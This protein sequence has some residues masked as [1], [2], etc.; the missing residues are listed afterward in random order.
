MRKAFLSIFLLLAVMFLSLA[1]PLGTDAATINVTASATDTLNGSDGQCSLREAITNINNAVT[2]YADCVPNGAYGTNDTINIPAGTYTTATTTY[3]IAKNVSIVG[4]GAGATIID[5]NALGRVFYIAD[6]PYTVAISG[7]TIQHG[8]ANLGG[9][10]AIWSGT[11]TV[12]N[13]TITSNTAGIEGGAIYNWFA[14]LTVTKSTISSNTANSGWGGGG[15][16]NVGP[17]TVTNS[18]ITGNTAANGTA[19]GGIFQGGSGG[20]L[21]VINSTISGNTAAAG[22][23]IHTNGDTATL[24]NSI[25]ANQTAGA[26]CSGAITSA[27]H[28]LESGTSCGFT[29]TGDLRSTN[30]VL[31]ALANNGGPTQTMA[32]Q[33]SSPAIDAGDNAICAAASVNGI[34][35]RG[36]PRPAGAKCDIGAFEYGALNTTPDAFSFAAQTG[37]P[38]STAIVSNPI[39][40]TGI[41]SAAAIAISGNSG[42]YSIST[43][44]GSTWGSWTSTPATVSLNNQVK[45]RQPSS[46]SNSTLTTTTLTIG[47]VTGDFNAT[48]AASGDPN[49]SGLVS[50]WKAENNAYDSVGG[51]HGTPMNGTTYATGK[52]GQAFSFDGS[53]QYVFVP[54]SPSLNLATGHTVAFWVKFGAYPV[55]G[56]Y[57]FIANKFTNSAEDKGVSIDSSGRVGYGL[58]GTG[59]GLQSSGVLLPAVWNH[60]VATY[61]GSAMRIYINGALDSSTPASGDVADSTGALYLGY[62]PGRASEGVEQPFNGLLDEVKWYNRALS[63]TD[64]SKLAGTYPDAF[65]FTAQTGMPLSTTI[66]SNPITV[67]GIIATAISIT[68]GEYQINSGS[69]TASAGTVNNGDTV[70]VRQTSSASNSTL[71]TA[72]LTIGG[73]SGAFNVTTA[74]SSD[75]NASGLVAWWRAENNGY[76]SVGGNHGTAHGGTTYATGRAGQAFDLSSSVN[77]YVS[78]PDAANLAITDNITVASWFYP[79]VVT[80]GLSIFNRRN[81]SNEGGVDLELAHYDSY[82]NTIGFYVYTSAGWQMIFAPN[83]SIT[84]DRWYHVAGTYNN[85][86]MRLYLNGI[87]VSSQPVSGAINNPLSPSVRIG[88]NIPDPSYHFNGLIDEVK[89]YSRALDAIEVSKIAGTYPDAF[90]FTPRTGIALS[91]PVESNTIIVSGTSLPTTISITDGGQYEIN[92]SGTW[93]STAGTVS[94]GATVKVRL[95]S[96]DKY[97]DTKT[98]TLTIGGVEGT[99]SVTTLVDSEKPQVTGFTLA[100]TESTF[101]TVAVASFTATDNSGVVSGYLVT[102]SATPPSPAEAGWSATAL[103]MTVTLNIAGNNTLYAW[104]KDPAGNVSDALT[105]TVLLKPVRREPENYYVSL[106][107]AYGE[108]DSGETIRA[109]AVTLTENIDLNLQRDISIS[110][111]YEDGYAG[112]SGYSTISGWLTIGKGTLTVERVV[113]K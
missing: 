58:Y 30:P 105:A 102:A 29:G 93:L 20:S 99:F 53:G 73:V 8:S 68:G 69:W 81:S 55:S 88:S 77:D 74:A 76:D 40:V 16:F 13:S 103:P 52:V 48:T 83:G 44:S 21:N 84:A 87:E 101:M 19:G 32:L 66:V 11:L 113:V 82:S 14:T 45:V 67:T 10:I 54:N 36:Y 91:T 46:A 42:E 111:G 62:N 4:A 64:V 28:N 79:R 71:T 31:R 1:A 72:T 112:Q 92:S 27:G 38:V 90:T 6:G 80:H 5:G 3:T 108:A 98:A 61:D 89:I 75:P 109:L 104:A 26:D 18:T 57:F 35:Q 33:L 24:S 59:T 2:T 7:V 22:G 107:A 12:A 39:T 37:M 70:I 97:S 51:N 106:Q 95:T 85:S 86:M 15:I 63:A 23:G 94:P 49:A 60:F 56:K 47:G 96:S 17:L 65:S 43:D 25:V 50:W 9:G 100:A 41:T 110:G 34:D 78:I